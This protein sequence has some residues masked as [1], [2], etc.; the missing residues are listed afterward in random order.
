[1][2][3]NYIVKKDTLNGLANAI[4]SI[5]GTAEMMSLTEMT[6]IIRSL[7][8]GDGEDSKQLFVGMMEPYPTV[9]KDGDIFF[10]V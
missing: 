6:S 2:A 7:S 1:M 9:G 10:L 8:L 5:T 4:R 3:D